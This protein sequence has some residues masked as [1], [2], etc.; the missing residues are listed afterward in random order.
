FFPFWSIVLIVFALIFLT[1]GIVGFIGY[2][3][4]CR[5]PTAEEIMAKEFQLIR[6]DDEA[7]L[8]G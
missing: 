7:L 8:G 2:L 6:S 1:V 4:G 5:R 3:L